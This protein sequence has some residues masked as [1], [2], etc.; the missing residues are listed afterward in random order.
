M[1]YV[2]RYPTT[3]ENTK[4][5]VSKSFS[6]PLNKAFTL[7]RT[8]SFQFPLLCSQRGLILRLLLTIRRRKRKAGLFSDKQQQQN[9]QQRRMKKNFSSPP[10][11]LVYPDVCGSRRKRQNAKA[12]EQTSRCRGKY[13][14]DLE[15][16]VVALGRMEEEE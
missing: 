10:P 13:V 5:K 9:S 7:A 12:N 6:I 11:I 4:R 3:N 1:K 2:F 14:R 15:C 16:V 8:C